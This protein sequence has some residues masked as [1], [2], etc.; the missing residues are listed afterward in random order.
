M[1]QW[2]AS[3]AESRNSILLTSTGITIGVIAGFVITACFVS[4]NCSHAKKYDG[5]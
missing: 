3:K 1:I 2:A 4:G 5:V